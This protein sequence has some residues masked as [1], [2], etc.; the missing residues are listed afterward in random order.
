M[1]V[2]LYPLL[3]I[4]ITDINVLGKATNPSNIPAF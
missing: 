3:N 2:I 1:T 4:N